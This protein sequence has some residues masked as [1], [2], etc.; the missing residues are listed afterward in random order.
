VELET[1]KLLDQNQSCYYFKK[2]FSPSSFA[3]ANAEITDASGRNLG[4]L[5]ETGTN[6]KKVYLLDSSG[7]RLLVAKKGFWSYNNNYKI[8][9]SKNFLGFSSYKKWYNWSYSMKGPNKETILEESPY[10]YR[11]TAIKDNQGNVVA[12]YTFL[13]GKGLKF[14]FDGYDVWHLKI[15]DSQFD[16]LTL[17]G[18]FISCFSNNYDIAWW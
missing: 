2:F 16:R 7:N 6:H 9:D 8:F 17:L 4:K 12:T 15:K 5:V 10:K 13:P 14:L 11:K 18:F 3:K 1:L